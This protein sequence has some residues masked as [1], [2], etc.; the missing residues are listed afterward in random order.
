[1]IALVALLT[2]LIDERTKPA[3]LERIRRNIFEAIRE[4]QLSPLAGAKKILNVALV[5][6]VETP[7][8]HGLGRRA[9]VLW[10]PPQSAASV[11]EVRGSSAHDPTQYV[12]LMAVGADTVIDLV[13]F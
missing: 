3:D 1:M 9:V 10:S 8:P 2:A 12:V 6:G 4:L 5:D 11:Q 7:I 13:V